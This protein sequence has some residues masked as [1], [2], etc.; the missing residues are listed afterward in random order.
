MFFCAEAPIDASVANANSVVLM[1]F[2]FI[3]TIFGEI[4]IISNVIVQR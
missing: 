2:M 3:C 4:S 1:M